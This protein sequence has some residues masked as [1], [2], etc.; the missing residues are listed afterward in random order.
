[1]SSK[2]VVAVLAVL[3]LLVGTLSVGSYVAAQTETRGPAWEYELLGLRLQPRTITDESGRKRVV[4]EELK[5]EFLYRGSQGWE[6]AGSFPGKGETVFF[7]F[8]RQK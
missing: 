3:A 7:V 1:M 8:K 2:K 4:A 6:Y 5:S